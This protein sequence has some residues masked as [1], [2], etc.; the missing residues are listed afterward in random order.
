V[1]VLSKDSFQCSGILAD[2]YSKR[3]TPF[4]ERMKAPLHPGALGWALTQVDDDDERDRRRIGRKQAKGPRAH[5]YR[6]KPILESHFADDP[7]F[8]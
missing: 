5:H 7:K 8:A 1:S 6:A 2:G 3:G 4:M